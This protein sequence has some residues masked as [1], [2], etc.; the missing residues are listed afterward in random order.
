MKL[1]LSVSFLIRAIIAVILI[2]FLIFFAIQIIQGKSFAIVN[3]IISI[4]KNFV[5]LIINF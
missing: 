3:T 2:A 1:E 4:L 5:S